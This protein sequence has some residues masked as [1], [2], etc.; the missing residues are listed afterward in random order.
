MSA[1]PQKADMDQHDRDVCFVPKADI[2][3]P[4]SIATV[5]FA[6]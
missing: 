1:L 3:L 5:E 2:A 6:A 4:H